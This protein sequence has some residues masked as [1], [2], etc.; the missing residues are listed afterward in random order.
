MNETYPLQNQ[1]I[2]NNTGLL[3]MLHAPFWQ[4]MFFVTMA[5][6]IMTFI[7]IMGW[8]DWRKIAKEIKIWLMW[9]KMVELPNEKEKRNK[10]F[11]AFKN[12]M[13]DCF[14]I[15]YNQENSNE[16]VENDE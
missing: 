9:V 12:K 14:H 3:W 11:N 5:V 6:G 8:I 4:Q 16:E 10:F 2:H 13:I 15:T 1:E 7:H